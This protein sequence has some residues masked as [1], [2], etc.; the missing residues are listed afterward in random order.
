MNDENPFIGQRPCPNCG[1]T[2]GHS[3][4][5]KTHK[6]QGTEA[7]LFEVIMMIEE[8]KTEIFKLKM[9]ISNVE[10]DTGPIK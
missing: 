5:C 10:A 3:A 7:G 6:A 4:D 1:R 8:L 2:E 9:R